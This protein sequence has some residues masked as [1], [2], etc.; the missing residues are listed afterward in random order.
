MIRTMAAFVLPVVL[1]GGCSAAEPGALG[2][3]ARVRLEWLGGA[4][5]EETVAAGPCSRWIE[6]SERH[7]SWLAQSTPLGAPETGSVAPERI[8]E[9]A[10]WL[11]HVWDDVTARAFTG[12]CPTATGGQEFIVSVGWIPP[13]PE[14]RVLGADVRTTSTC[15]HEWPADFAEELL[16]RWED[17]GLPL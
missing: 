7:Q 9:L 1:I 11:D 16:A 14:V 15:T 17:A 10:R 3:A 4:C 13:E 5:P 8:A 12:T 6:A 2:G